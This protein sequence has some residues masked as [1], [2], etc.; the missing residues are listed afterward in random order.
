MTA[1]NHNTLTR[2]AREIAASRGVDFDAPHKHRAHWMDL[3]R[4]SI[5]RGR[6]IAMADALMGIFGLRRRA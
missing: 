2:V 6:G 3:A 1:I 4:K 5:E